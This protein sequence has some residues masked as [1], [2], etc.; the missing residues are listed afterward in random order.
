[1][2]K[3][4]S[5]LLLLTAVPLLIGMGSLQGPAS[6]DKIPVTVKKYTAT[7]VDQL[8]VVT[9]CRDVSIEGS[10]FLEGRR[11]EGTYTISFDNIEKISFRLNADQLIGVVT[12]RDGSTSDLILTKNQKAYGRTQYGTFQVK[13]ADLKKLNIGGISAQR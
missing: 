12:L 9:E 13:L 3:F 10:T 4:V 5:T 8:D 6:P 2:K 11:G 7:F 1:M